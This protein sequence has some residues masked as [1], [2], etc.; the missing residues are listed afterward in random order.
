VAAAGTLLASFGCS[1]KQDS[2]GGSASGEKKT[3]TVIAHVGDDV[4][5]SDEVQARL[6]EQAP[7]LRARYE[8]PAQKKEFVENMVKFEILSKEAVKQH[9]DK[10]PEAQ[11]QFKRMLV[12]ELIKSY[13]DKPV[14]VSDD[15]L[16]KYYD[17]HLDDYVKPEKVR[18]QHIFLAGAD[19]KAR[20]EAKAKA[21]K[22]LAQVKGELAKQEKGKTP[23]A[24]SMPM[25]LFSDLAKQESSDLPT[26]N[27]GGD[28][29]FM[30][31]EELSK[32]YSPEFAKAA[33]ALTTES[34]ISG[35]IETPKGYH[36][37]RLLGRQAATNQ[38]FED[39]KFKQTL[40][41]RYLAETRSQRFDE[42]Y[43]QLK[44]DANVSID[45]KA[46]ASV[47]VPKGGPAGAATPG[48]PAG[49]PPVG[50]NTLP[51]HP[52]A[53]PVGQMP[54]PIPGPVMGNNGAMPHPMPAAGR[55]PPPVVQNKSP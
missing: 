9:L 22:L 5:T 52:G 7:F 28:L 19:G 16:K 3:G 34:P 23:I 26:K 35:V 4:I 6:A 54:H 24:A 21:A 14:E 25:P 2:A 36:I 39:P 20:T 44:K 13:Y 51:G 43:Q 40:K 46:L 50:M 41:D 27:I 53:G 30:S 49:H 10:T 17:K 31:Q 47:E 15:D 38:A 32:S 42:Y 37:A 29:R 1:S 12:Q 48:M 11:S 33:F 45:E 55:P 18:V 8:A